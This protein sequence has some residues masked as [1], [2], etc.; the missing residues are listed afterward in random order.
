MSEVAT[1]IDLID[2]VPE[3]KP[4]KPR[5]NGKALATVSEA[6]AP[7]PVSQGD[8]F[9]A[10]FERL[11]R[12]PSVD[13]ARIQ[14]FLQMKREEEDR[15]AR[16]AFLAAFSK[17][18]AELPA[19]E[20][21]GTG[22]NSKK[23]ARFEDFIQTIRTHL[24]AHG[25][26]LSFRLQSEQGSIRIIGVL[27]HEAGHQETTDLPLPADTTGNKNNVQAWGS[28]IS[29]GKRY[30]GMTLL[31]IATEDEDDDAK[32]AGAGETITDAQCSTILDKIAETE[33]DIAK[34]CAYFRVDGVA[35]LQAK[36]YQRA[37]EALAAKRRK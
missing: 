8:A 35:K 3:P 21:K 24:A 16:G 1:P 14:Q 32:A 33:S 27:G 6:P 28:T 13:P 11:A 15:S 5:G 22:H 36:D 19:V 37:I 2:P 18:Q 17:L 4:R 12:D 31:G 29:Y 30:V 23:Y 20:R 25:F 26:S 10:L 34:F 7:A 9:A